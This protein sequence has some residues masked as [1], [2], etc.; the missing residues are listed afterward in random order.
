[1][2]I[3]YVVLH[4]GYVESNSA[5]A[6]ILE[7]QTGEELSKTEALKNLVSALFMKFLCDNEYYLFLGKFKDCC[8]ETIESNHVAKFCISCGFNLQRKRIRKTE[9]INFISRLVSADADS[10]GED[11]EGWHPWISITDMMKNA[12]IEEV[13]EIRENGAEVV[14]EF[15][16]PD[17][18]PE[19]L[20]STIE[21]WETEHVRSNVV[22]VLEEIK[23]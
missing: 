2:T 7:N 16:S 20:R 21:S 12:T 10:W 18:V 22:S 14:T 6:L 5:T 9:F 19:K 8:K 15:L 13:L 17:L 11:I 3:K 1:M 23:G 4:M